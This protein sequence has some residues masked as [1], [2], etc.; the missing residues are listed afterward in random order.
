MKYSISFRFISFPNKTGFCIILMTQFLDTENFW[1]DI[2]KKQIK[3]NFFSSVCPTFS[4][5]FGDFLCILNWSSFHSGRFFFVKKLSGTCGALVK[6][7]NVQLSQIAG[8]LNE[9]CVLGKLNSLCERRLILE[10]I[11]WFRKAF[12]LVSTLNL[13][14]IV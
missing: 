12:D 5:I 7:A 2:R 9:G 6:L 1:P 14:L 11:F 10:E 3:S 8:L 13:L 4:H